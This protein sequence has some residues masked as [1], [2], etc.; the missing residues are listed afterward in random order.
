MKWDRGPD[1]R[2]PSALRNDLPP[3]VNKFRDE[4]LGVRY[5]RYSKRSSEASFKIPNAQT[6]GAAELKLV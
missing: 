3:T 1:K 2:K 4:K 5:T 6:T